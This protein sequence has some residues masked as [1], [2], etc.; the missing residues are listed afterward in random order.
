MNDWGFVGTVL[1]GAIIMNRLDRLG[2]QLEAVCALIRR[3]VARTEAERDEI[4][5]DWRESKKQA[6]IDRRNAWIF[7]GVVGAASLGWRFYTH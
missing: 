1:V 7:W 6:A 3:D 4:M 5:G 2:N